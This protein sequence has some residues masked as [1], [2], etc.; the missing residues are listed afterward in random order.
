MF[1]KQ[2]STI[3]GETNDNDHDVLVKAFTEQSRIQEYIFAP[4]AKWYSWF[5]CQVNR[6]RHTYELRRSDGGPKYEIW[7]W[8]MKSYIESYLRLLE[9]YRVNMLLDIPNNFMVIRNKCEHQRDI[10]IDLSQR[11]FLTNSKGWLQYVAMLESMG[12]SLRLIQMV[13][14]TVTSSNPAFEEVL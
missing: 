8:V 9:S 2:S 1:Q 4:C 7:L 11:M 14:N 12:Y 13:I 5:T 3:R 10:K 6:T